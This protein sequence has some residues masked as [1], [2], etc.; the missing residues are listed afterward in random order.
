MG[1]AG[2][3]SAIRELKESVEARGRLVLRTRRHHEN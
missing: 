3:S 2:A 1:S